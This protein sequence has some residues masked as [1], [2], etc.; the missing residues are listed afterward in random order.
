MNARKI[1]FAGPH[2]RG[3]ISLIGGQSGELVM[4][5]WFHVVASQ[6]RINAFV[7][8]WAKSLK[9]SAAFTG[10]KPDGHT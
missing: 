8:R 9:A 7:C 5:V 6:P 3:M 1:H 10:M 4:P 2:Q